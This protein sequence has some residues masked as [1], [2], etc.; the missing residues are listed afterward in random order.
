MDWAKAVP[1]VGP[2]A[3]LYVL[4]DV[5]LTELTRDVVS[6]H[7]TTTM[8]RSPAV[9][10]P[11]KATDTEAVGDCGVAAATC[12]N[13]MGTVALM[14]YVALA[15]ALFWNPVAAAMALIVVVALTLMGLV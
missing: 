12:A 3:S 13:A 9:C 2:R 11:G 1:S 15:T 6:F 10:A 14:V 5:S 7:P 4:P 8:F